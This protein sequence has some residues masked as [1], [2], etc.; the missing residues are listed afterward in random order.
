MAEA[1]NENRSIQEFE[2]GEYVM[3][4]LE[5]IQLLVWAIRPVFHPIY[6]TP[7]SA[8]AEDK[9]G[10]VFEPAEYGVEGILAHRKRHGKTEYLVQWEEFSSTGR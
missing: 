9:I 8:T 5:H 6:I 10:S 1:E 4:R 7:S 2:T 3:F